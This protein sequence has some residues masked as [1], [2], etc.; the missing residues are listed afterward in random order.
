M[1]NA[2]IVEEI[3][4]SQL[5]DNIPDFSV[6]DTVRVHVRIV[7]A[8]LTEGV[9]GGGAK[10]AESKSKA[11]AAAE[12]ERIQ[13][14]TGTVIARKGK[15]V[16]ETFSVH[17]VAYGEGMERVFFLH[18][19]RIATIE[20]AKRGRVRRSKLYYL[21]GSSGKK[22]KVQELLGGPKKAKVVQATASA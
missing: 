2:A 1:S 21:R 18:S 19:P 15:G 4:K 9:K 7:E 11:K 22:A 6:G 20:I 3:G 16:S 8:A 12:K 17:R 10:T 13:V 14:F 5:K